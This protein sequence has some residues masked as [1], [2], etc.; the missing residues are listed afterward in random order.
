MSSRE[1]STIKP[2]PAVLFVNVSGGFDIERSDIIYNSKE[3]RVCQW[4][5]P[6]TNKHLHHSSVE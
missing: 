5:S 3:A 2:T 1:V 4:L 6:V